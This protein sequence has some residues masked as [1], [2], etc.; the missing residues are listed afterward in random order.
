M[1]LEV[2]AEATNQDAERN[3][4]TIR[5]ARPDMTEAEIKA[6]V[7]ALKTSHLALGLKLE[8]LE[9]AIAEY[10]GVRYAVP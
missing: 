5:L 3:S 6:V 2:S 4:V 1:Q 7:K 9:G 8:E 10:V